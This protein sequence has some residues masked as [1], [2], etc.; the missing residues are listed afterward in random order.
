MDR[1]S[2]L[3]SRFDLVVQPAPPEK[4]HLHIYSRD[5]HACRL[6]FSARAPLDLPQDMSDLSLSAFVDWGGE[7]NPMLLA[8]P[9]RV[10]MPLAE[11]PD[12]G[13]LADVLIQE[14]ETPRC[15]G[16]SVLS[17]LC[18]VLIVRLLRSQIETGAMQTG[19]LGGL[20]DLRLSRA[21]VAMHDQPEHPWRAESLAR[22]A[23]LSV[24]RFS[25]LFRAA[26]GTSPNAYLRTWRLTLAKRDLE[27]G[28]RVQSVSA[29]YCYGS[30]E[31]L[32]RAIKQAYGCSPVAL[33]KAG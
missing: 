27:Q 22:E 3:M 4:A 11:M 1:L 30:P 10:E 32:S 7:D 26:V 20:A 19:L 31:A 21:I 12:G 29:R 25:E 14:F 5:G 33:R 24:S 28:H 16:E 8:L 6:V 17:R 2:A 15:G 23:G 9:D 13:A 18:E